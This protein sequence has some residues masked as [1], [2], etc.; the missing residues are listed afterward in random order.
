MSDDRLNRLDRRLRDL[1]NR[2]EALDKAEWSDLYGI[3][4][5][6]L[7]G[8]FPDLLQSLPDPPGDYVQD[9]FVD[10][11]LRI[12]AG[13][14]DIAHGGA[15]AEFYKRYLI[16]RLRDP[17]LRR[18]DDGGDSRGGDDGCAGP[19]EVAADREAV[20]R[21]QQPQ[22]EVEDLDQLLDLVAQ[23]I[24][25]GVDDRSSV[26]EYAAP[27]GVLEDLFGLRLWDIVASAREFLAGSGPW[28]HLAGDSWW[29]RIYLRDHFCPE[30]GDSIA[31]NALAR[32]HRIRSYHYKALKLGVTVPL[33]SPAAR[34]SFRK[35]YRGR[36][37]DSLGIPLD[38][39]H[40][41]EVSI[42]LK[43]LCVAALSHKGPEAPA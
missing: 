39:E 15:L 6:V 36:W 2:R 42:A 10:K 4:H 41:A 28:S 1:W 38:V 23:S 3:V 43:V 17:Y 14:G 32:F 20:Q 16:S 33:D 18:R 30:R 19:E 27:L 21:F 37:L 35:S 9:F 26:G 22:G 25:L 40:R 24:A 5:Q 13:S 34:E 29:I 12:G 7:R 8:R 11:V 31:L